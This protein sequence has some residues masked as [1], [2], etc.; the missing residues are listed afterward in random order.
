MIASKEDLGSK[1]YMDTL[2]SMGEFDLLRAY[3]KEL[4]QSGEFD[5][6][7]RHYEKL[8]GDMLICEGQV[9]P[10]TRHL[11]TNSLSK[12][13]KQKL[14]KCHIINGDPNLALEI[15]DLNW[16]ELEDQLGPSNPIGSLDWQ[17]GYVCYAMLDDIES[18]NRIVRIAETLVKLKVI[19]EGGEWYSL[20]LRDQAGVKLNLLMTDKSHNDL[21][22]DSVYYFAAER[23]IQLG[24]LDEGLKVL[25]STIALFPNSF[26]IKLAKRRLAQLLASDGQD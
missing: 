17:L 15:L 3:A 12:V 20:I 22:K 23:I 7:S 24:D 2:Y 10:L 19:V 25:K 26:W 14:A 4:K 21:S 1:F 8:V 16:T 5:E 6:L 13:G 9:G 11:G 18:L